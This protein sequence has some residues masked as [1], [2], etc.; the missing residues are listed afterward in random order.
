[1]KPVFGEK[2]VPRPVQHRNDADN[3]WG[4]AWH[5]H[6]TATGFVLDYATGDM[7]GN[8]RS[9]AISAGEFEQLRA[10]P[11]QFSAIIHAHGG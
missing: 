4:P 9:F 6:R 1:M 11:E 5:A 8:D 10:D 7:A 3:L 2:V